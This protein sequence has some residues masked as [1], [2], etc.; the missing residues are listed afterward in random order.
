MTFSMFVLV[1]V[2]VLMVMMMLPFGLVYPSVQLVRPC[3][4]GGET[5]DMD[6]WSESPQWHLYA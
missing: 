2:L 1:L 5:M 3:C 6:A 4:T